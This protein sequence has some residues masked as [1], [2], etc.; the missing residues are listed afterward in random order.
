M[1]RLGID[2]SARA[3]FAVYTTREEIDALADALVRV[4]EFFA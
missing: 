1:R 2:S 4:R 3:S